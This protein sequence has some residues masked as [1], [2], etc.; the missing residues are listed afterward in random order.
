MRE[1]LQNAPLVA[2]NFLGTY[3]QCAVAAM[4]ALPLYLFVWSCERQS[5]ALKEQINLT[6]KFCIGR[7]RAR[8]RNY[9]IIEL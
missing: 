8:L 5:A 1:P 3:I 2:Y 4:A 7:K 6:L 9:I